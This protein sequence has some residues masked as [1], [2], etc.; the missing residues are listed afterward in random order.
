M[1]AA[2]KR[3]AVVYPHDDAAFVAY[4]NKCSEGKRPMGCSHC[5]AVQTFA[6]CCGSPA[7]TIRSA[8]DTGDFG[9]SNTAETKATDRAN[10]RQRGVPTRIAT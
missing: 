4:S 9:M 10:H 7:V 3:T 6:V 5:C 2:N 1:P 8:V